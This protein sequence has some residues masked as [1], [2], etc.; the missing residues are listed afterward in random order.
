MT[1]VHARALLN[2]EKNLALVFV[3]VLESKGLYYR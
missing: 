1:L 2:I 3:F